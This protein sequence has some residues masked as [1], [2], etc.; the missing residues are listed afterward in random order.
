MNSA[1]PTFQI[2]ASVL[3]TLAA[4][5]GGRFLTQARQLSPH[6]V[7]T[8]TTPDNGS[9]APTAPSKKRSTGEL[10]AASEATERVWRDQYTQLQKLFISNTE[11]TGMLKGMLAASSQ[12]C[13]NQIAAL[14]HRI[15]ELEKTGAK[16]GNGAT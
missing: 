9:P 13:K 12:D 11:Q 14:L 8:K 3:T 15:E 5:I 7:V 4:L 6:D 16:N 1:D 10:R 2:L